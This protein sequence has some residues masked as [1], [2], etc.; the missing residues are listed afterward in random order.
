MRGDEVRLP[1]DR[2]SCTSEPVCFYWGGEG[3][4]VAYIYWV[5]ASYVIL[6]PPHS[7]LKMKEM[8]PHFS[9]KDT[10]AQRG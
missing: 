9:D 1:S 2:F 5:L 7:S 8:L 10:K 3:G 6:F 4:A